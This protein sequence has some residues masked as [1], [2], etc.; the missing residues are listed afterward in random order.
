MVALE[1]GPPQSLGLRAAW[2]LLEK[3]TKGLFCQMVIIPLF[4]RHR[5]LSQVAGH[6]MYVIKLLPPLCLS[7]GRRGLDRRGVR[8]RH[9]RL[10]QVARARSGT[11]RRRWRGTRSRARPAPE[12]ARDRRVAAWLDRRRLIL[13][14]RSRR[15]RA[16]RPA[17]RRRAPT[18]ASAAIDGRERLHWIDRRIGPGSV[19]GAA[20]VTGWGIGIG[21]AGLASLAAVP[22]VAPERSGRLVHGRGLGRDRRRPVSGIPADRDARRAQAAARPSRRRRPTTTRASARCSSMPRES[23]PRPPPT[24][25][26]SGA[27]GSTLETSPSTPA[28]CCSWVS[29]ITTGRRGSSTASRARPSARRS[30]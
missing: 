25:A 7:P 11:W 13:R 8:R 26:G 21:A 14:V 23:W 2:T 1:F 19:A 29:D 6:E 15:R 9:R 20:L 24:N 12:S 22:F 30:S 18:R 4:T 3:A 5:I 16:P 28:C 17:R 10:P 27:G